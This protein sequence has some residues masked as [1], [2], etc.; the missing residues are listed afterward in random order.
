MSNRS[1]RNPWIFCPKPNPTAPL[2]LFCFPYAGGGPTVF[3]AWGQLLP[4]VEVVAIQYPGRGSRI[5]EDPCT[6]MD[7]LVEGIAEGILPYLQT[8]P[9]A[10]FGHS[11][12][13]TV[14]FELAQY[15][16]RVHGLEPAHLFV[17][18]RIAP[19]AA[20]SRRPIHALPENEFVEEITILGGTPQEVLENEDL[21]Q[22]V[23][24][25]LRADFEIVETYKQSSEEPL[26]C[27]L[28]AL[29]GSGDDRATAE[30]MTEWGRYTRSTFEQHTFEGGHFFLHAD[31]AQ[32][33]VVQTVGT[34]LASLLRKIEQ[35]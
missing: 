28:T 19:H 20:H 14:S 31:Q 25:L 27:G 3:S 10:F 9:F 33:Q 11:M 18:G 4:S 32:Q 21:M 7:R 23:L 15:L 24:P 6:R 5:L 35:P 34:E 26:N 12:G 29:S 16:K 1:A 8:K 30:V 13:A 17:S 22:L 2:R